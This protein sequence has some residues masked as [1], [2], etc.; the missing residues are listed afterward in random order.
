MMSKNLVLMRDVVC[1]Y[2]PEFRKSKDIRRFGMEQPEHFN[3]ER[4]I[5]ESLAA[6][7]GYEFVDEEGYDFSDFSDSKTTTINH[8]T[9]VGTVMG[10]ECKIGSLRIVCYNPQ[11]NATDYFFVRKDRVAGVKSA[12]YGKNSHKERIVFKYSSKYHDHYNWF[13]RYRVKSFKELALAS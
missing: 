8:T 12:C 7:G 3:V 9:G 1:K 6:V 13:E 10:V 4:L 2:H 11:K 5:E